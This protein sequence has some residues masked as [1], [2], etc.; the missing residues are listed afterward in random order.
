MPFHIKLLPYVEA[1]L[2][3]QSGNTLIFRIKCVI[4]ISYITSCAL[5]LYYFLCDVDRPNAC[6][7][8][9]VPGS[10][11]QYWTECKYWRNREIC[12]QK[13]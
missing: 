9:E 13:A 11:Y 4:L 1:V 2:V 10:D 5:F 6:V 8:E 3:N 12:G 7:V